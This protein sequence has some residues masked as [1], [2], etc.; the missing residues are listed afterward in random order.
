MISSMVLFLRRDSWGA[1]PA[2]ED[3][4]PPAGGWA[5]VVLDPPPGGFGGPPEPPD[6]A[7]GRFDGAPPRPPNKLAPDEAGAVLLGAAVVAGGLPPPSPPNK[8]PPDEAGAEVVGAAVVVDGFPPPRPPNKPPPPAP[9]EVGAVLLG[10]PVDAGGP[11]PLRPPNKLAPDAAGVVLAGAAV[12]PGAVPPRPPNK[13]ADGA[14]VVPEG[15]DVDGCPPN[16]PD[17]A[18]AVEAWVLG[19]LAAGGPPPNENEGVPEE[20]G[21]VVAGPKSPGPVVAEIWADLGNNDCPLFPPNMLDAGVEDWPL[22]EGGLPAGV[23]ELNPVKGFEGVELPA[24]VPPKKL[25]ALEVG[26]FKPPPPNIEAGGLFSVFPGVDA[27]LFAFP[28][29][30]PPPKAP[31]LAPPPVVLAGLPPPNIPLAGVFPRLLP[32]NEGVDVP[33]FA[34]D[35]PVAPAPKRDEVPPVVAGFDAALF[36]KIDPDAAPVVGVEEPLPKVNGDAM[37]V[38]GEGRRLSTGLF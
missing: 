34:F 22:F 38:V 20:A 5:P 1:G 16:K 32:N 6:P 36:P 12:D 14:G 37:F 30:R 17:P 8:P 35:P 4:R 18:V 27:P 19:V 3:P 23:V 33:E 29:N 31:P 21:L 26:G 28:P 10:A 11:P 7:P 13:P 9:E 24:G 2:V 25:G 15:A